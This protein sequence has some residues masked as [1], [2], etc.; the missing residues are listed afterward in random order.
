[1]AHKRR[2]QLTVSGEWA[3]Y[4]RK[5]FRRRFWKRERKAGKN[6]I[7]QERQNLDLTS[8]NCEFESRKDDLS[9]RLRQDVKPVKR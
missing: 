7:L 3:K 9:L 2:G 8:T 5:L 6:L 1:M 4:L